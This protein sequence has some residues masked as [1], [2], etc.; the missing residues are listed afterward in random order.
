MIVKQVLGVTFLALIV[1]V[2][3][4]F[5]QIGPMTP[6]TFPSTSNDRKADL[7]DINS[8]SRAQ[9]AESSGIGETYAGKV[10]EGRPYKNKK[11]LKTRKILTAAN[12]KQVADK[13]TAKQSTR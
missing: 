4:S 5:G 7:V 6:P 1:V 3:L 8:A 13:I 12:Y 9:L 11:E 2:T 10:I